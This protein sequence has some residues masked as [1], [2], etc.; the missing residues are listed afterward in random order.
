MS[1]RRKENDSRRALRSADREG[2]KGTGKGNHMG[3]NMRISLTS[4]IISLKTI[5]DYLNKSNNNVVWGL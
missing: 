3:K 1:W 4:K 5:M 2:M